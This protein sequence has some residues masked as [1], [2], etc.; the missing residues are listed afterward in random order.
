[1]YK[2]I[3][4]CV[5][6]FIAATAVMFAQESGKAD[7]SKIRALIVDGQNNH[8]WRETTPVL[9]QDLEEA[10]IFT[11]DVATSPDKGQDFSNFKPDFKAYDVVIINYN[12]DSWCDETKTAFESYVRN[13][14][15]VVIFHAGNNAFADWKEYNQIIAVGGWG[16]R[17]KASGPYLYWK[18]GKAVRDYELDGASGS[19]GRQHEFVIEVRNS[20]H[21]ITKGLPLRFRHTADELYE[22]L[23]GPAENVEILATAWADPATGGDGRQEPQLMVISYGE[24]RV[25]H[26]APGHAG[27]QCRSVAFIVTFCRGTQWAATG[28]VTLPVPDDMP[29]ED[30]SSVRK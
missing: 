7:G 13:G 23:R 29:T 26:I 1:M 30:A 9:K 24:G 16:G 14:G 8:N 6:I 20:E 10:G 11:V 4:T 15:G 22:Q 28:K 2:R 19:H 3:L 27:S 17:N 25:F 18:D 5:A 21:P 12:G